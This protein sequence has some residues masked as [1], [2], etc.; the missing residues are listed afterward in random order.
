MAGVA[1][2]TTVHIHGATVGSGIELA[3]FAGRVVAHRS[4]RISLPEV[5]LG[6]I[7]GA[8][9]TVSL[10]GRIGRHAAAPAGPGPFGHRRRH[11]P[12]LGS[13]RRARGV[14]PAGPGGRP[15]GAG[16]EG[17]RLRR[18]RIV[19]RG[20]ES[21]WLAPLSDDCMPPSHPMDMNHPPP[22]DETVTHRTVRPGVPDVNIAI[23]LDLI[24]DSFGDRTALTDGTESLSYRDLRRLARRAGAGLRSRGATTLAFAD[25][26]SATVPAAL[27]GAAS[28]GA[29]YAPLNF[30]LPADALQAQIERLEDPFAV[31]SE[32]LASELRGPT[33]TR[34]SDWFHG[35]AA[36]GE[37]GGAADAADAGFADDPDRAAVILFTSGSSGTPKA[38]VLS[39]DNLTS[40][41]MDTVEFAGS[42]EDEALLLAAP[43]FHIAGVAAV[44]TSVYSGRRILPLPTFT[45]TDWLELARIG[46]ATHAFVVPTML[47]RIVQCMDADSTLR[48]PTLRSLSYG[49]ARMGAP[50]LERALELFP[51]V[52]FVNA[53]GLT[54]TSSTI[55][56]LGP[57]DHRQAL[58]STDPEARR[59]LESVGRP[60]PGVEVAI[61]EESGGMAPAGARG[62]IRVRGPQVSGEYLDS[63]TSLDEAGW[64]VTGDVG[65]IDE[66]GYLYVEGRADD[67]IIKGGENLSPAEIED[68]APPA[69]RRRR[70][71]RGGHPRSR[72]GGVGGRRRRPGP[73]DGGTRPRR[74]HR[75]AHRVGP[76]A[77][78]IAEDARTRRRLRRSPHHGQWEGPPPGGARPVGGGR[79]G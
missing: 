65:S 5:G 27:F 37:D 49:G 56:V 66:S 9:G 33:I 36:E 32:Q 64:L 21:L 53:Y 6:L 13:G 75:P 54:E 57:E 79:A 8:G 39:H 78:R 63:A 40:Y 11:G 61:F 47:A 58:A 34:T 29:S 18:A 69:R 46:G 52:Q 14:S 45:P 76:P 20:C 7:P 72:V 67:V 41:V 48:V 70:R 22:P 15:S 23:L 59:R 30:R 3:T 77:P 51:E 1:D 42:G 73:V 62:L 26:C 55:A 50:I 43:P 4:T 71:G 28:A 44:L 60:L 10:P 24:A 17:G 74:D 31:A 16:D 19:P 38:A 2:R 35:L 12:G 68:S 25:A